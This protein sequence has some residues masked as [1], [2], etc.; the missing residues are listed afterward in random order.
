MKLGNCIHVVLSKYFNGYPRLA[1]S[2]E[3]VKY[4]FVWEIHVNFVQSFPET[5]QVLFNEILDT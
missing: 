3:V 2:S 4:A 5:F 1:A